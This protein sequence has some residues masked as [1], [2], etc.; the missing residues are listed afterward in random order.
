[1]LEVGVVEGSARGLRQ[2]NVKGGAGW[3]VGVKPMLSFSGTLFESPTPNAYTVAKSL[4]VDFFRG[5]ETREVDVEGLQLL[6]SF[7]VGEEEEGRGGEKP[8]IQ[9]RCWRIVTRRSEGRVPRVEVVEVGPRI[10][11]RVGRVR[12]AQE[13]M[14]KEAMRKGKGGEAKGRKNVETDTVG[15][16][17]GRIHLGR[18]DLGELQSRKMKGLKRGRDEEVEG[19]G[20]EEEDVVSEDE[21]VDDDSDDGEGGVQ[22]KRQK[23]A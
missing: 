1:M 3:Q 22:V 8:V 12:E 14:W 20:V 19:E 9:M 11:M 16:K 17:I 13:G 15:D 4:F 21:V 5:G 6:I 2:F 18:Q 23:V 10:D 7:F